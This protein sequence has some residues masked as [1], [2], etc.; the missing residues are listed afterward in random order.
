MKKVKA[1]CWYEYQPA[2]WDVVMPKTA[3]QPGQVVQVIDLP[4]Y[5]RANTIGH[6][7]V[8]YRD[9]CFG[10]LVC[11]A[12]LKRCSGPRHVRLERGS[13]DMFGGES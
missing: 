13:C 9:G 10:G 8:Q 4:G 12:S 3:L 1:G 7:Y 11:V 6:C 5:P 2:M